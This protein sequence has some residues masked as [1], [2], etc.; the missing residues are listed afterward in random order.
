MLK[1]YNKKH[2]RLLFFALLLFA[3][4]FSYE[5]YY[6]TKLNDRALI[7]KRV[8]ETLNEKN[9]V[10]NIYLNQLTDALIKAG[11]D[12]VLFNR[13]A[14][15]IKPPGSDV[16][17]FIYENDDLKYWSDNKI[18]LKSTDKPNIGNEEM[19]FFNSAYY[20]F[21]RRNAGAYKITA[22]L[23]LKRSNNKFENIYVQND[24]ND[25]FKLGSNVLFGSKVSSTQNNVIYNTK[26]NVLFYLLFSKETKKPVPLLLP[27]IYLIAIIIFLAWYYTFV[28]HFAKYELVWAF[29]LMVLLGLAFVLIVSFRLPNGLFEL[30]L[31]LP[32]LYA[33]SKLLYS[34]GHLLLA[35]L[36]ITFY[37]VCFHGYVN[38][39]NINPKKYAENRW[40][41]LLPV[42]AFVVILFF[43]AFVIS[44]ASGLVLNS[45]ISFA[46]DNVLDLS[47]Y[48]FAGL[49]IVFL[50]MFSFYLVCDAALRFVLRT[51]YG[52]LRTFS[53]FVTAQIIFLLVCYPLRNTEFFMQFQ[54]ITYSVTL[55]VMAIVGLLLLVSQKEYTF[56]KSIWLVLTFSA[57]TAIILQDLTIKKE[58]QQR[59][60]FADKLENEGDLM[61]EYLFE[62]IFEK[63]AYDKIIL[64]YLCND[65]P[66][67]TLNTTTEKNI[68]NRLMQNYFSGYWSGYD[69]RIHTFN[70]NGLPISNT[71]DTAK[72]I[73]LY[74][75]IISEQGKET[76]TQ[77]LY[78]LKSTSGITSYIGKIVVRDTDNNN[79]VAGSII[80]ELNSKI[81]KNEL[82]YPGLLISQKQAS[83]LEGQTYSYALYQNNALVSQNGNFSYNSSSFY[84]K[85]LAGPVGDHFMTMDKISYLIRVLPNGDLIVVS[86]PLS[87]FGVFFTIFIY[88][89]TLFFL[90]Y[91]F[92][93]IVFKLITN[94]FQFQFDF[95]S[96]IQLTV[97]T[98]III[99]MF[100]IGSVTIYNII[101]NYNS[102]QDQKLIEKLSSVLLVI[103]NET[104]YQPLTG[105]TIETE[106]GYKFSELSNALNCDFNIY[107]DKGFL[108]YSTQP[109]VFELNLLG[110]TINR[111]AFEELK[112]NP[113]LN[114][115]QEE[116]IGSLNYIAAYEP[117]SNYKNKALAYLNLPYFKNESDLNKEISA[118]LVTLINIY[119]PVFFISLVITL[120]LSQRLANPLR[121]IQNSLSKVRLD[122]SNQLIEWHRDDEIGALVK[123]YNH[124][125]GE[126]ERS[127]EILAQ[128]E[129]E[130]AW[131]E[132]ARQ[133]AHEIKN[134]L[135]PMK[136][137]VQHMLRAMEDEHP[138]FDKLV[139]RF[140]ENLVEQIDTLS[141]IATEFSNFA[142]MPRANNAVINLQSILRN[143]TEL[144]G[145]EKN[146]TVIFN[147]SQDEMLVYADKNQLL[148]VFSNLLKNAIQAIP[149]SKKGLVKVSVTEDT[150]TYTVVVNDNGSGIPEDTRERIFTPN[151]T[152]K[153]TGTGLGLAIAKQI[154]DNAQGKI[155]FETQVN[156]GTT[157]YIMLPKYSHA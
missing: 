76:Q 92:F 69:I 97:T 41:Q 145:I 152:T 63:L 104:R 55:G 46:V 141:N 23:F 118:I 68:S 110:Y 102:L 112:N 94:S 17:I 89:F 64:T 142:K 28:M 154:V 88:I 62:D 150:N 137:S 140:S 80:M 14:S 18:E 147:E 61:A 139:K 71:S 98:V 131:R 66:E 86:K 99:I 105:L 59:T 9:R 7:V 115:V 116:N 1:T 81:T 155:W 31:F 51:H 123:Q 132:M 10:I 42:M 82:G 96:R 157:F 34:L 133:V 126:L 6:I 83:K 151:F 20:E 74:D 113:K 35:T 44:L 70:H 24:F 128:S 111:T 129:R 22:L 12:K 15:K 106:L 135:T 56:Y 49:V 36:I 144:Y 8:Q 53:F 47:R 78:S 13:A 54:W 77:G 90:W 43:A 103:E 95:K 32:A 4:G 93:F 84:Y 25:D 3:V 29:L 124:M 73:S 125:V 127:A 119:I 39:L 45:K 72:S 120:F 65:N 136:L 60:A 149:Q 75:K 21:F 153:T 50:L 85:A 138:D 26:R 122:K 146:I 30:N 67:I 37:V 19:S 108:L 143:S 48:S 52:F 11:N 16:S 109:K 114:F 40:M 101:D 148:R 79:I 33:S 100:T 107:D 2:Y 156:V 130:T 5:Y 87:G 27:F 134:P 38:Q 58:Q 91:V 57:Y 121:L 117:I